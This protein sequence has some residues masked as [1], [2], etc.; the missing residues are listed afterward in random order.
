[1]GRTRY[2]C[3]SLYRIERWHGA[4]G[5][6][7]DRR[8]CRAQRG[9]LRRDAGCT[10]DLIPR[11]VDDGWR[12]PPAKPLPAAGWLLSGSSKIAKPTR[13]GCSSAAPGALKPEVLMK[14]SPHDAAAA[15]NL[16]TLMMSATR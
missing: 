5:R 12:D 16:A 4:G 1:M 7:P 3:R 10:D 13:R 15:Q 9:L 8:H 2:P 14:L 11:R 6:V